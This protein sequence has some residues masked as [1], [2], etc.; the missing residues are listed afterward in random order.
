MLIKI[1]P[2]SESKSLASSSLGYIIEHQSE[3]KR[4]FD[5]GFE[6]KRPPS[7]SK[8]PLSASYSA[9]VGG[10]DDFLDRA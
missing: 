3:W 7:S 10:A 8:S 1:E 5:S 4:P 6:T 2:S 9:L